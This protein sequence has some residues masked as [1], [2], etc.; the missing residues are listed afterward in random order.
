MVCS[1]VATYCSSHLRKHRFGKM[2]SSLISLAYVKTNAIEEVH[3]LYRNYE[4]TAEK[5][6]ISVISDIKDMLGDKT[7]CLQFTANFRI[8][9]RFLIIY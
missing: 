6:K 7:F 3:D 1:D 4:K 9:L 5:Y 8:N 2:L